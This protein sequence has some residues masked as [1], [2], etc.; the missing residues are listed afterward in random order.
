MRKSY[1]I[2]A[3]A[4]PLLGL[5]VWKLLF[6]QIT[7]LD[8]VFI[9]FLGFFCLWSAAASVLGL[10]SPDSAPIYRWTY[11]AIFLALFLTQLAQVFTQFQAYTLVDLLLLSTIYLIQ[12]LDHRS[13]GD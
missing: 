10:L 1:L 11:A 5:L 13:R 2:G 4:S 3:L 12:Y 9:F 6:P 8:G 7:G